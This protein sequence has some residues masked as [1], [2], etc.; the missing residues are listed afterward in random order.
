M[1]CGASASTSSSGDRLHALRQVRVV[2]FVDGAQPLLEAERVPDAR[3][4]RHP[5]VVIADRFRTVGEQPLDRARQ[6]GGAEAELR[7]DAA[8]AAAALMYGRT[9]TM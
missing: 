8:R 6:L 5:V 4:E 2:A 3:P 7:L 1:S 9:S